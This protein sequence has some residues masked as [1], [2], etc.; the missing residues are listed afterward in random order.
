MVYDLQNV[1]GKDVCQ[2]YDNSEVDKDNLLISLKLT[3]KKW[4]NNDKVYKIIR[5]NKKLLDD[6]SIRTSGLFRS[7]ILDNNGNI[8]SFAPPKSLRP[9]HFIKS[10]QDE[11]TKCVAERYIEGTMINMF[12]SNNDWEIATRSSVGAKIAFFRVNGVSTTFRNMFL[13]VCNHINLD[14]D[15]LDKGYCYSFVMQHPDN[16][17]VAP[18][19]EKALYLTKVY[20]IEGYTIHEVN[21]SKH[22]DE[23]VKQHQG[24]T[25]RTPERYEFTSFDEL[26]QKYAS[27]NTT[28]DEVGVMVYSPS[29]DRTKFR[30]PSYEEVRSLRGNQPKLQYHY[31]ALRKTGQ[32]AQ[33]LKY[34]PEYKQHFTEFRDQLHNFTNSL[35]KNYI[36][37]YIH[38]KLPLK[39][40]PHQYRQMMFNLHQYYLNE[41]REKGD[42]ISRAVVIEHINNMPAAH[43]MYLLNYNMRKPLV[44]DE[45]QKPSELVS[46]DMHTHTPKPMDVDMDVDDN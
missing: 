6:D 44:N 46:D 19:I 23:L 10:H 24:L 45:K 35:H 18:I 33:F 25:L 4:T 43:Q 16:R 34:F 42:Y 17:I 26:K 2:L 5:Y 7:V 8:V 3:I 20:R 40:F 11:E 22:V 36:D 31:L 21:S 28:Y 14:F 39:E 38:K 12:Y 13:E 37:C 27:N 41:L 32:I 30:N 15:V 9:D 1:A 29:G